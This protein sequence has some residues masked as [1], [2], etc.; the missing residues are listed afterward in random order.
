LPIERHEPADCGSDTE[1][2]DDADRALRIEA[3][4]ALPAGAQALGLYGEPTTRG[5]A[6]R[7]RLVPGAAA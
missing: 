4:Y 6:R 1:Q 7:V 3:G 5:V 2:V